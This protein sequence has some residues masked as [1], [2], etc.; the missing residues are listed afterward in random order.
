MISRTWIFDIAAWKPRTCTLEV[1]QSPLHTVPIHENQQASTTRTS[2]EQQGNPKKTTICCLNQ[3]CVDF[4]Q[5]V[6]AN[7][8]FRRLSILVAGHITVRAHPYSEPWFLRICG[9]LC[10]LCYFGGKN[11][12]KSK[13]SQSISQKYEI[14]EFVHPIH[15]QDDKKTNKGGKGR[16]ETTKTFQDSAKQDSFSLR[17][18]MER[19]TKQKPRALRIPRESYRISQRSLVLI[20]T[21]VFPLP[22]CFFPLV[23]LGY[24]WSDI[25]LLSC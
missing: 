19:K 22:C 16:R 6:V 4:E 8:H 17:L 2:D 7:V 24:G 14:T 21:G 12:S 20:G 18:A 3:T 9:S 10:S 5:K 25:M 11:I 1:N 23:A 15:A 13:P